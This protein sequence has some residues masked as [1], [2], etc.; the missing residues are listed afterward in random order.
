MWK[1]YTQQYQRQLKRSLTLF[2]NEWEDLLTLAEN[3]IVLACTCM[4]SDRC[5]RSI[6]GT[7]IASALA[8]VGVSAEYVGE[9]VSTP[10]QRD[11]R[12]QHFSQ[13]G[14]FTQRGEFRSVGG[15]SY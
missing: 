9:I 6:L 12:L 1:Q 14:E 13:R 4:R 10:Q 11:V 7:V 3:G 8:T 5:H 2:A 15:S